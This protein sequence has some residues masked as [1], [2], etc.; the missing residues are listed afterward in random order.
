MPSPVPRQLRHAHPRD[1]EPIGDLGRYAHQIARR[2]RRGNVNEHLEGR[3]SQARRGVDDRCAGAIP[4]AAGQAGSLAIEG[5]V[6]AAAEAP[7]A[8]QL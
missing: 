8:G 7:D 1:R 4:S 6:G 5:D 3:Q 2:I